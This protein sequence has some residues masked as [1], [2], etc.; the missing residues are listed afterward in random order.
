MRVI[1]QLVNS[2]TILILTS[3]TKFEIKS[4]QKK[5][6]IEFEDLI[7]LEIYEYTLTD[8]CIHTEDFQLDVFTVLTTFPKES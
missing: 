2:K 7:C 6:K 3:I 4:S 8:K 5:S 1:L